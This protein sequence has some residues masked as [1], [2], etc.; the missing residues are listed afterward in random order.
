MGGGP[1][2]GAG[3]GAGAATAAA[4]ATSTGVPQLSQN[5]APPGIVEPQAAQFKTTTRASE[6]PQLE[7]NRAVSLFNPPHAAHFAVAP[8]ISLIGLTPLHRPLPPEAHSRDE[9]TRA[10][11]AR[12]SPRRLERDRSPRSKGCRRARLSQCELEGRKSAILAAD[13]RPVADTSRKAMHM[14]IVPVPYPTPSLSRRIPVWA[15]ANHDS[16]LTCKPS[17]LLQG[18]NRINRLRDMRKCR[19]IT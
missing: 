13:T 12:K 19:A 5:L 17:D 1:G 10:K 18:T 2:G 3:T 8:I 11:N 9:R 14:W 4:A 6:R 16:I 15:A 7:Q